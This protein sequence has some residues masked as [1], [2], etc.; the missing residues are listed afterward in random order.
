M[1]AFGGKADMATNLLTKDQARR[2]A[3]N[4]AKLPELMTPTAARADEL[5][6]RAI[7]WQCR[8]LQQSKIRSTN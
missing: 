3:A 8:L 2:I 6:Q 5:D 4:V 1:S 7:S